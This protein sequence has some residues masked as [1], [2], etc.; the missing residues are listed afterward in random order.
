MWLILLI[1]FNYRSSRWNQSQPLNAVVHMWNNSTIQQSD[2]H[3][4][5]ECTTEDPV[6][7]S[8]TVNHK[9][10]SCRL[11]FCCCLLSHHRSIIMHVWQ[12]HF[13][14]EIAFFLQLTKYTHAYNTTTINLVAGKNH[15]WKQNKFMWKQE[16]NWINSL[17]WFDGIRIWFS[18]VVTCYAH[19]VNF[20]PC[21][22]QD[23]NTLTWVWKKHR[24]ELVIYKRHC[25]LFI[26]CYCLVKKSGKPMKLP[27]IN[28][29]NRCR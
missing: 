11:T 24:R 5:N 7:C 10:T 19:L 8:H 27:F 15:W 23:R 2:S 28:H 12:H 1:E 9:P 20:V 17:N 21:M 14:F 13:V 29:M 26:F 18:F 25:A 16:K 6:H 4:H 22:T 3:S